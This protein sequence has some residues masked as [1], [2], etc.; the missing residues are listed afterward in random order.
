M[1]LE[2]FS[3]NG[4]PVTPKDEH[5]FEMRRVRAPAIFASEK[6]GSRKCRAGPLDR[7]LRQAP[8]PSAVAQF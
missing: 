3:R 4:H 8:L 2:R 5:L 7:C 6:S 1:C